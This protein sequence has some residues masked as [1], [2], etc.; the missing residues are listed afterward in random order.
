MKKLLSIFITMLFLLIIFS[1]SA[2]ANKMTI[3]TNASIPYPIIL[4]HGLGG[5]YKSWQR[6]EIIDY[7]QNNIG[8]RYGG[9]L[10]ANRERVLVDSTDDN[11]HDFY[12]ISL[13]PNNNSIDSLALA[14]DNCIQSILEKT[15][16]NK[17]ILIGFSLGGVTSRAYLV[18]QLKAGK[19]PPV[20]K[21]ITISSPHLGTKFAHFCPL[22]VR[23][24]SLLEYMTEN[25]TFNIN[26]DE[27]TKI[28]LDLSFLAKPINEKISNLIEKIE[29]NLNFTLDSPALCELMP[30]DSAY[31][32]NYLYHL[33]N[34]KMPSPDDI[35]YISIISEI[36]DV[37]NKNMVQRL[38]KAIIQLSSGNY[39]LDEN[40]GELLEFLSNLIRFII[41]EDSGFNLDNGDGIIDSDRQLLNNLPI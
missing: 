11:G 10:K 7:L 32:G 37:D 20:R 8:L 28:N 33:N 34:S 13:E 4:V 40:L 25:A 29:E 5:D 39:V 27:D 16:A 9:I 35:D 24:D 19:K 26:I 23:V 12:A 41:E 17:V 6:C 22:K 14:L 36:S 3:D 18:E 1:T 15:N 21:L 30:P 31:G 38:I 2:N